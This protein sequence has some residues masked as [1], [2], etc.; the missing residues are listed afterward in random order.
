VTGVRDN[1]GQP[2]TVMFRSFNSF[3]QMTVRENVTIGPMK[4]RRVP[5]AQAL[6]DADRLLAEV[7]QV[8]KSLAAEV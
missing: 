7:L 3:P 8:M 6:A 1:G 2:A 5:R 4:V